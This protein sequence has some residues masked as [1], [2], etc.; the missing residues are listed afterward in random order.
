ML[1][2]LAFAILLQQFLVA[3]GLISSPS[4]NS[5]WPS[6][7]LGLNKI[8]FIIFIVSL[9]RAAVGFAQNVVAGGAMERFS[10]RTRSMLI[11][12]SLNASV[13]KTAET[14]TLFNERIYT[15]S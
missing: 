15:A 4:L 10:Y 2:E 5:R 11:E 7:D 3:L 14:L 8:I 1:L 13:V 9:A 6:L 12:S